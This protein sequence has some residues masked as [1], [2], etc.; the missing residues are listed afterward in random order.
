MKLFVPLCN[1]SQFD[2]HKKDSLVPFCIKS[3]KFHYQVLKTQNLDS[4][5]VTIG[6]E[7]RSK[8][9]TKEPYSSS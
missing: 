6:T 9:K 2:L 1:E 4:K 7:T 3:Y 5:K 8:G